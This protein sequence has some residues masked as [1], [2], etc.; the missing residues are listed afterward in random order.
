MEEGQLQETQIESQAV[1]LSE[2]SQQLS[3]L[4]E[5][6]QKEQELKVA[7][8][9]QLAEQKL[10]EEQQQAELT[11][12]QQAD[13]EQQA[14]VE[15]QEATAEDEY[16]QALLGALETLNSNTLELKELQNQELQM[17]QETLPS[18]KQASDLSIIFLCLIPLVIVY[19][20]LASMFNN[21]F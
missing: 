1:D 10:L 3:E 12:Q 6:L 19:K 20:W 7:E 8:Q 5:V 18:V 13:I 2:T 17:F 11:E 9:E 4:V 16:R 15:E 21:A 14:L